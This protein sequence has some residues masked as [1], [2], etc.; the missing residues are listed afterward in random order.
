MSRVT[1]P[2]RQA[3]VLARWDEAYSRLVAPRPCGLP[4]LAV[5]FVIP[6]LFTIVTAILVVLGISGT[7]EGIYWGTFGTGPDPALLA[8]E[9]RA[10]RSDEWLVQ[11]SWIVSQVQ[12]GFPVLN[13]AFPGGMDATIQNDLPSEDWSTAFRPHVIGFL[14]FPIDNGMA[15]RWWL[16]ALGLVIAAYLFVVSLLPRDPLAAAALALGVLLSPILQWWFLPTTLWPVVFAFTAM[17]TVVCALRTRRR[18]VN[19]GMATLSGYIAVTMAMSIYVPFM[20]P[21]VLA[22][23]FFAIGA[24]LF[25]WKARRQRLVPVLARLVPL[26][27][28]AVAAVAVLVAWILTR[29]DTVEAVTSTVYPG[30]RLELTGQ[31]GTAASIVAL[32]SGP[33]QR[34]LVNGT[35]DVLGPNQSEASTPIMIVA[36]LL[37]P[38][39]WAALARSK[40]VAEGIDYMLL[41]VVAAV[42]VV[43]AFLVIP[44]WD[45]VA[46]LLFIDRT[47]GARVR[48]AFAVLGVVGAVLL[49][50]R[51]RAIE[52][53]TPWPLVGASLA[54]VALATAAIWLFLDRNGSMAP[55]GS[56]MWLVSTFFIGLTVLGLARARPLLG[57]MSLLLATGAVAWGVNPLYVGVFDLRETEIGE[58][59]ARIALDA[60]D[61]DWV[62]VGGYVPTAV[63]LSSG[64][65]A[66]NGVQTYPP[67]EMWVSID[68]SG[69]YEDRWNRLANVNWVE[70]DGEPT[71]A[72]PARD[73]IVVSFDSCSDFAQETIEFVLTDLEIDQG[74]L[75]EVVAAAEGPST[76][77]IYEVTGR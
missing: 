55:V 66:F 10:I 23:V 8:G 40:R 44:G 59:V 32:F 57:G 53:K 54:L 28:A 42:G 12:Q 27:V 62:G 43:F 4:N 37:V 49:V 20:V 16:P 24:V 71:V 72:N 76:T 29:L 73:Q 35:Y 68:P 58:E 1:T 17:A 9:P 15:I 47:T 77:R 19:S 64:V 52:S 69:R 48:L 13:G 70:G 56:R 74:C 41:A 2:T 65:N 63:L 25:E 26:A 46:H 30:E 38:M 39:L 7:S 50:R 6:T 67:E 34:A 22:V 21:A 51:L 3:A 33:F 14:L 75:R 36:F 18:W 31:A 61:A 60:P 5:V 45:S 11:S